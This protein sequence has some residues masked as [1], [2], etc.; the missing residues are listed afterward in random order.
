MDLKE[1]WKPLCQFLNVA[2]PQSEFPHKNVGGELVETWMKEHP[3]AIQM[4][5]ETY[6]IMVLFVILAVIA[7]M[8]GAFAWSFT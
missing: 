2:V 3:F 5:K 8:L 6:V 1:G 4:K 7:I